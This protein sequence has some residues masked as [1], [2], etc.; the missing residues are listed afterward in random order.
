MIKPRDLN[1]SIVKWEL[2]LHYYV[3]FWFTEEKDLCLNKE[4]VGIKKPREKRLDTYKQAR[5][6]ALRYVRADNINQ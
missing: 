6:Y 1:A 5:R 3:T 4:H 2:G